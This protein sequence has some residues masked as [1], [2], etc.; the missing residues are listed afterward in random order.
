[1]ASWTER[2]EVVGI[3]WTAFRNGIEV[4]Q[5]QGNDATTGGIATNVARFVQYSQPY[6]ERQ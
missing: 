3:I 6:V 5:V 1:M 2:Q 4:M